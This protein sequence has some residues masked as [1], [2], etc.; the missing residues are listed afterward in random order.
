MAGNR[1]TDDDVRA[2]L[3]K[4]VLR[5]GSQRRLADRVGISPSY[6]SSVRRG[7]L[8][9]SQLLAESLGFIEDGRRWIRSE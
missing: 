1:Y 9:P 4:A 5:E 7:Q 3:E 8:P 6:I 2:A